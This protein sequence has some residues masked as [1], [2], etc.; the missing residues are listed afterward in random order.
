MRRLREVLIH[1]AVICS[2]MCITA[3]ILDWYNPYMNFSG[4][5]WL[6]PYILY[7]CA[8]ALELTAGSRRVRRHAEAYRLRNRP[9]TE[10]ESRIIHPGPGASIFSDTGTRP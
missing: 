8:F 6:A 1:V 7:G 2:L 9:R 3:K 10:P 5:I 4:H